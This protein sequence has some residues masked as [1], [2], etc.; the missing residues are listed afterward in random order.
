MLKCCQLLPPE[1]D[2]SR[3]GHAQDRAMRS[4]GIYIVDKCLCSQTARIVHTYDSRKSFRVATS[5][6]ASTG[7]VAFL[8]QHTK[9]L[10]QPAHVC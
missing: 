6:C 1:V 4:T 7:G 9:A 10:R 5:P 8:C 2:D 3:G